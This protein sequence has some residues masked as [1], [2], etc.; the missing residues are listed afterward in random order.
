MYDRACPKSVQVFA[1]IVYTHTSLIVGG[2]FSLTSYGPKRV[3]IAALVMFLMKS[4][5]KIVFK[6]VLKPT[7]LCNEKVQNFVFGKSL[8]GIPFNDSSKNF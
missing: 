3:N 6:T 7:N 8:D 2:G 5:L 1:C 4:L